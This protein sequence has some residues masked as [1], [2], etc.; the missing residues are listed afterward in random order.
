MAVAATLAAVQ[1]VLVN[2]GTSLINP[3]AVRPWAWL[4]WT[5]VG[6]LSATGVVLGV[7]LYRKDKNSTSSAASSV[8]RPPL[9]IVAVEPKVRVAAAD[10]QLLGVHRSIDFHGVE[11]F[12]FLPPYVQRDFDNRTNGLRAKVAF[13]AQRGGFLVLVGG[14]SV[15]KTRSAYEAVR[16]LL[17]DWWLIHPVEPDDPIE[18]RDLTLAPVA[19]TVVWLD[20]L[21]RYL[22]PGG[23]TFGMVRTL[24]SFDDPILLIGTL[25]PRRYDYYTRQPA[26][27]ESAEYTEARKILELADVVI[28]PTLFSG[29]ERD[30]A[31]LAAA[32]DKRLDR[33][34]GMTGY[35]VPQA[36]AAAPQLV[37]RWEIASLDPYRRAVLTAAVDITR[38]GVTTPQTADLLKA[39]S[40]DY[41]TGIELGRAKEHWQ[42][43]ALGFATKQL[44]GGASALEPIR[45]GVGQVAY[46][47]PDY[48]QQHAGTS[49]STKYIPLSA[50]DAVLRCCGERGSLRRAAAAAGS[51]GLSKMQR[52]LVSRSIAVADEED[53]EMSSGRHEGG[54]VPDSRTIDVLADRLN[55]LRI[56]VGAEDSAGTIGVADLLTDPEWVV[57]ATSMLR[58]RAGA[59]DSWA[60]E[61]CDQ[62][63]A[64]QAM[65]EE[66][67]SRANDGDARARLR[68][69][70]L[71]FKHAQSEE[72]H[73]R[74]EAGDGCAAQRLADL[75]LV[76]GQ[77]DEALDLLR[78]RASAGDSAASDRL[79]DMLAGYGQVNEAVSLLMTRANAGDWRASEKAADLLFGSGR[80]AEAFKLLRASIDPGDVWGTY[81]LVGLLLGHGRRNE[82]LESLRSAADAGNWLAADRLA[83]LLSNRDG[84]AE[85][86]DRADAGDE[87]AIDRLDELLAE[88]GLE[89]ELQ[90]RANLGEVPAFRRLAELFIVN[91]RMNEATI[92]LQAG[93]DAG[94][95][96]SV[97]QLVDL[98]IRL[99][100]IDGLRTLADSGE[101]LAAR[102][103]SDLLWERGRMDELRVRA[104]AGDPYADE[105]LIAT[106]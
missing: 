96:E 99:D 71:L 97:R 56:D 30:R 27:G 86:R 9:P 101:A 24:L 7:V 42:D 11:P 12:D 62:L 52:A 29:G 13:A 91:S 74:A 55:S 67:R 95:E 39:A 68:L 6:L 10:P 59:G 19:R 72:L 64:A 92:M 43:D 41:L 70:D 15:G 18:I 40:K 66:L 8:R 61:I 90:A 81:Q 5:I 82:A 25:W 48:L 45:D 33:S 77:L 100:D 16:H 60:G 103:L 49:R 63:L 106:N 37:E 26:D 53:A 20:D 104:K 89:A 28:V 57:R 51:A 23:L 79:A 54:E 46:L 4:I 31:E 32:T 98:Q 105:Y 87:R 76:R 80:P 2:I 44:Y 50:W 1:A 75:L 17:A 93:V 73:T 88:R 102:K 78:G 69:A 65:L 58:D 38:M 3:A 47:V 34:L 83:E 94:D 21:Q 36:L 84:E 22:E 14:S 85:L 35:S